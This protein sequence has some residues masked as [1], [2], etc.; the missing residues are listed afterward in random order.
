MATA[1]PSTVRRQR[2][3]LGILGLMAVAALWFERD[4]F[5][6]GGA[7]RQSMGKD[8]ADLDERLKLLRELPSLQLSRPNKGESFRGKRD[9][10]DFTTSPEALAAERQRR[11][12]Q[13]KQEE[14]RQ[15]QMAKAAEVR[16]QQLRE[17]PPPPPRPVEP[18]PPAFNYG[19]QA[20]IQ[21][22]MADADV[23]VAFLMKKGPE[24]KEPLPVEVGDTIDDT[25]VVKSIDED[26]LV[27]GYTNPRFT[28]KTETVKIAKGATQ[29]G[30]SRRR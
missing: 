6:G 16:E 21:K 13:K 27:V 11:E 23:F 25:F 30:G 9:L 15:V 12:V 17:N 10:F 4:T 7:N 19:Y 22:R 26:S 14:V 8:V 3:L 18:P 20:Y 1:D 29:S 28:T 24:G 2:I 5:F